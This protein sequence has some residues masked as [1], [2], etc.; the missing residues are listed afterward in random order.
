[1]PAAMPGDVDGVTVDQSVVRFAPRVVDRP[2]RI[3]F[4]DRRV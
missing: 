1:M 3:D 4:A 2:L